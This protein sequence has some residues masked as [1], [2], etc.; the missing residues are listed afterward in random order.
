[1]VT[2]NELR[3]L[4]ENPV[5]TQEYADALEQALADIADDMSVRALAYKHIGADILERV[6]EAIPKGEVLSDIIVLKD[7]KVWMEPGAMPLTIEEV[8]A[9]HESYVFHTT[10]LAVRYDDGIVED[11]EDIF[12]GMRNKE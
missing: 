9:F 12:A 3:D 8:A 11:T 5:A 4:L 1:M 2:L 7:G 6:K 10:N